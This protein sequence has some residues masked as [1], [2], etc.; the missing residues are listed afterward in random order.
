LN[1]W[2]E[3][4]TWTE[5]EQVL[6]QKGSSWSVEDLFAFYLLCT[7]RVYHQRSLERVTNQMQQRWKMCHNE[8]PS[9]KRLLKR[10]KENVKIEKNGMK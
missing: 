9:E 5:I 6:N 3:T 4:N 10:Y 1:S 2:T 8:T 7:R